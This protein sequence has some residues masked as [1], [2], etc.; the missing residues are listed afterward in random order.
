M[1]S[2]A[3]ELIL[4]AHEFEKK[5]QMLRQM[6]AELSSTSLKSATAI[7]APAKKGR[8]RMSAAAKAIISRK[9]K[10]KWKERKAAAG[11]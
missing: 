6:A 11:K 8:R 7:A 2:Q 4:I 9:M 3:G 10:A 1:V 5:A